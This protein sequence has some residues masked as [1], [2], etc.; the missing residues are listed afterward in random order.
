MSIASRL[1]PLNAVQKARRPS[2][3][4]VRYHFGLMH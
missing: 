2:P 3:S 1:N 4:K